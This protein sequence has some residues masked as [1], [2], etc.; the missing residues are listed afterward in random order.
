MNNSTLIETPMMGRL[1]YK[2]SEIKK[3]DS[4]FIEFNFNKQYVRIPTYPKL[5]AFYRF[6]DEAAALRLFEEHR[7]ELVKYYNGKFVLVCGTQLV[8]IYDKYH[9]A[10]TDGLKRFGDVGFL[11]RKITSSSKLLDLCIEIR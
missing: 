4:L 7:E 8:E 2:T 11:I 6:H 1:I 3:Q 5:M 9:D 10:L